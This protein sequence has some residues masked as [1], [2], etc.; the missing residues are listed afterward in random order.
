MKYTNIAGRKHHIIRDEHK[1]MWKNITLEKV[2]SD[3]N[4]CKDVVME[5]QVRKMINVY[6]TKCIELAE[7]L[8]IVD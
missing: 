1:D 2:E 8:E 3:L 4:N 5:K 7:S 6:K